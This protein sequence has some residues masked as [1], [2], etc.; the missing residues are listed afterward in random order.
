MIHANAAGGGSSSKT[1]AA[2]SGEEMS[3]FKSTELACVKA[4]AVLLHG[5]ELTYEAEEEN[6]STISPAPNPGAKKAMTDIDKKS[7]IFYK[8]FHVLQ[9]ALL[10]CFVL[11]EVSGREELQTVAVNALCN[12]LHA[13]TGIYPSALNSFIFIRCIIFAYMFAC[14]NWSEARGQCSEHS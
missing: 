13:N 9:N 7:K 3:L 12:L 5:I 4:I 6:V 14:R 11:S 1:A 2:T 10:S 8:Y